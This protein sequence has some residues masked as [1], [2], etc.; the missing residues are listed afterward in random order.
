MAASVGISPSSVGRI[1]AQ[2]GLKPHLTRGFKVSNDPL[3]EE[4]VTDIVGLYTNLIKFWLRR[5]FPFIDFVV[6]H[7]KGDLPWPLPP[8]RC[9]CTPSR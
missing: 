3:S 7:G 8:S 5:D 4:K 2:A 1:R 9:C 6:H